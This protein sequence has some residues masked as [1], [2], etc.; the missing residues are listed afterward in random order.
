VA[1][2]L[3]VLSEFWQVY[4][5][6]AVEAK[7]GCKTDHITTYSRTHC[8][9]ATARVVSRRQVLELQSRL[10]EKEVQLAAMGRQLQAAGLQPVDARQL[11]LG[12]RASLADISNT[13]SRTPLH[14]SPKKDSMQVTLDAA[15]FHSPSNARG[16]GRAPMHCRAGCLFS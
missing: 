13:G 5:S 14:A 9:A 16:Q 6:A 11:P 4:T 1:T 15:A 10:D 2:D 3:Q 7:P 8:S 12:V